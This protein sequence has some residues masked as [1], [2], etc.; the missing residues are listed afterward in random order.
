MSGTRLGL[1]IL[2]VDDLARS[3]DFYQ[4]AFGW[5]IAVDVPVYVEFALPEGMRLGL[6]ARDGFARNTGQAPLGRP[7]AGTTATE[8][9]LHP[10]DVEHTLARLIDAGAV[11]LS[12]LQE[13]DWGDDAAYLADPDGNVLVVARP[14]DAGGGTSR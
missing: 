2:A 13:R 11:L 12:P 4:A 3:V 6:Y 5:E 9:Y 14:S 1:V 7:A 8:L 10:E